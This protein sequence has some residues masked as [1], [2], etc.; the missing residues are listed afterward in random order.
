MLFK[1]YITEKLL[2]QTANEIYSGNN[3]K[4]IVLNK[5]KKLY[6][7]RCNFGCYVKEII[8]IISASPPAFDQNP[9]A[10]AYTDVTF[11]AEVIAYRQGNII[12][13]LKINVSS[14]KVLSASNDECECIVRRDVN[15]R[16]N[17]ILYND[18][19][20]PMEVTNIQY[21]INAKKM[22]VVVQ[23][24]TPKFRENIIFRIG[25]G[26]SDIEKRALISIFRTI[27]EEEKYRDS[28]DAKT[29][30]TYDKINSYLYPWK[31]KQ[32][33]AKSAANKTKYKKIPINDKLMSL[34]NVGLLISAEDDLQQG[35]CYLIQSEQ[36]ILFEQPTAPM[37]AIY[38]VAE[39]Y[40]THLQLVRNMVK[41][42]PTV[43]ELKTIMGFWKIYVNGKK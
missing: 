17:Q 35:I 37:P 33:F 22:A 41:Y 12:P 26:L 9:Y 10:Y 13:N 30:K 20:T 6:E 4:Q 38:H 14:G 11:E 7:N 43:I 16:A 36:K 39:L 2:L 31:S 28:M 8:K 18:L 15:G 27:K 3:F 21:N 5:L 34:E 29:K 23:L 42:Y 1:K 40:L 25:N 32:T 19:V 24:P